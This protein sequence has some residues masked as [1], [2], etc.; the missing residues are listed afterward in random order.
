MADP[1]P[2]QQA[3]DRRTIDR[4]ALLKQLDAELI[5]RQITILGQSRTN[6]RLVAHQ[7]AAAQMPLA[8]WLQRTGC[9]FRMIM[10]F[11]NLGETRKCRAASR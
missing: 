3:A 7:L 5:Q 8:S 9:R 6:P 1:E 4:D 10:S 2:M 11:T